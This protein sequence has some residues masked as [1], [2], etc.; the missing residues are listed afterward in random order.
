M[1]SIGLW[2]ATSEDLLAFLQSEYSKNPSLAVVYQRMSTVSYFYRLRGLVS[3]STG[4]TV[5][6]YLRGLKR[7][8]LESGTDTR[9]AK[10]LL[11]DDLKLLNDHLHSESRSLR[12]WRTVWRINLA[13]YCL[14]RWDDVCRLK[15]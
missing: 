2:N 1:N 15:V 8:L 5:A 3:P 12:T 14:L 6:M 7:R 11:K 9:R 10:P 4:P 13:F